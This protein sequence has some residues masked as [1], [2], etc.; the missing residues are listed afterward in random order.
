M[1]V[2]KDTEKQEI[3]L[4]ENTDSSQ[5][6]IAYNELKNKKRQKIE[7]LKKREEYSQ[8]QEEL[9]FKKELNILRNDYYY[10]M[11]NGC[12][13]IL[14][15]FLYKPLDILCGDAYSVRKIDE[16]TTFYF[17]VDGMGKGISASLT[18]M[19]VTSYVNHTIDKMVKNKNFNLNNLLRE[20]LD[21]IQPILLDEESIATDFVLFDANENRMKYA[22]F[23]M[24]ATLL[25]N[26]KHEIIK[27][28]SNNPPLSKFQ[29]DIKIDEV[30]ISDIEKFLFYSDGLVESPVSDETQQYKTYIEKDFLESFT[31]DEFIEKVFEKISTQDDDITIIFLNKVSCQ[32]GC[33][34]SKYFDTSLE[35]ID[36]ANEWYEEV[37]G[38]II[39]NQKSINKAM[40]AFNELF[41]NAYEHGNLQISSTLKH[42]LIDNGDYYGTLQEKEKFCDKKIK[43][44]INKIIQNNNTY[45]I[46]KITDEGDGFDTQILSKIFRNAKKFNGRGVFVSRQSSAGI[47]YSSKGN[48]VIYLT[49]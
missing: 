45:V 44:Q 43:V 9:T 28:K 6:L 42:Q 39:D 36:K 29:K 14:I 48:S 26:S 3:I 15:N 16:H 8:Y 22:K 5:L 10:Q 12:Y 25:E 33:V 18:S 32:K 34:L 40:L 35:D 46:T 17:I 21:Y 49:R 19:L 38:D 27:I 30:D 2:K 20:S 24:P 41:I 11:I 37:L 13:T 47:Y 1:E 7:E 4:S 31:K 23:A